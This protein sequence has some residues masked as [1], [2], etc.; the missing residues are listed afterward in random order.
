MKEKSSA[1]M[2]ASGI[3]NLSLDLASRQMAVTIDG[4]IIPATD[5]FME[6]FTVDGEQF[7]T[8]AYTIESTT[9]NGMKESR[10][11]FLPRLE[12]FSLPSI[13]KLNEFGLASK[14]VHDD[15]KAKA[16]VIDFFSKKKK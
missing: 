13:G 4:V 2:H 8:F 9:A 12:D 7:I 6:K 11:F 5:I 16:D 3:V 14:I 15:E 10:R 1:N